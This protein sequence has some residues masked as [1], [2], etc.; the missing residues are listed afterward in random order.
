MDHDQKE[1]FSS[2]R[3][4]HQIKPFVVDEMQD[5]MKM[6]MKNSVDE[7][8]DDD[9]NEN[10]QMDSFQNLEKRNSLVLFQGDFH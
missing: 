1:T 9:E 2:A 3:K 10:P 7:Q 6:M 8:N 5:E 4:N